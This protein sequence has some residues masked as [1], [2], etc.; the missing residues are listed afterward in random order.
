MPGN[1]NPI[2]DSCERWKFAKHRHCTQVT[3]FPTNKRRKLARMPVRVEK[4]RLTARF[5]LTVVCLFSSLFLHGF[6]MP[7]SSR[8]NHR[9]W[10][11]EEPHQS[12]DVL[13]SRR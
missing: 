13:R 6:F 9:G 5:A 1:G 10:L 7:R 12:L 3:R 2:R 4:L 8:R 11:A